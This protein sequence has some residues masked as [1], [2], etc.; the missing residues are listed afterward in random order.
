MS[1]PTEEVE[2]DVLLA[3]K[4]GCCVVAGTVVFAEGIVLAS[5]WLAF[6]EDFG[7]HAI[8]KNSIA[9]I[10]LVIKF[11]SFKFILL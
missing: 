8:T 1:N 5:A 3:G 9:K 10:D 7:L 4:A 11:I 6:C 2:A